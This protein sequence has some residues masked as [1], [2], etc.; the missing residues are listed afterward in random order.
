MSARTARGRLLKTTGAVVVALALV[1]GGGLAYA[2]ANPTAF[3]HGATVDR[4]IDGDTIEVSQGGQTKRVR[5]LNVNTPETVDPDKPV[6]CGGEEASAWLKEHLPAG[7]NV[8]LD[9]DREAQDNYGRDLAAVYKDGTLVNAEIARHGL[10]AAMSVG[11]N[12]EHLREVQDAQAEAEADK[13]GLYSPTKGCSLAGQVN[14]FTSTPAEQ[15]APNDLAT[16]ADADAA[17][18][19][20]DSVIGLGTHLLTLLSADRAVAPLSFYSDSAIES[21]RQSVSTRVDAARARSGEVGARQTTLR[22]QDAIQAREQEA[23]DRAAHDTSGSPALASAP[24]SKPA[25][26]SAPAKQP[27]Q[28]Q[29]PAPTPAPETAPT[30]NPDNSSAGAPGKRPST[31]APCRKYAPGGKSFTYIDCVTK[32]PI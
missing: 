19:H 13:V 6:E 23:A 32:Q 4:V 31:A 16:T 11:P 14:E 2:Q 27:A 25:Q 12:V 26:R 5:L 21:M 24:A 20:L 7:T 28:R 8:K 9:Y 1:A 17:A 29:T 3:M 30:P 22:E 18:A 15:T 10:G